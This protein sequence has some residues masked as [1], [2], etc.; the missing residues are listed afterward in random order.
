MKKTILSAITIFSIALN[1]THAKYSED[2]K[3]KCLDN[4]AVMAQLKLM[5]D[6][7]IS[8]LDF[9]TYYKYWEFACRFTFEDHSSTNDCYAMY[10]ISQDG[11]SSS[12]SEDCD[13]NGY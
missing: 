12:I 8:E 11:K 4:K 9:G 6:S 3:N 5:T 13:P 10:F 2:F 7:P 1:Y